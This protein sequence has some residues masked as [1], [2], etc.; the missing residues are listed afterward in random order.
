[1]IRAMKYASLALANASKRLL[2]AVVLLE[3]ALSTFVLCDNL[4]EEE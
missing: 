2:H 1:M 4:T 3:H